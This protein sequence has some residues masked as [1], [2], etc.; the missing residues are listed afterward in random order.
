MNIRFIKVQGFL[1]MNANGGLLNAATNN[2]CEGSIA[3]A[4]LRL[5]ACVCPA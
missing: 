2:H 5:A 3:L 4:L 1:T